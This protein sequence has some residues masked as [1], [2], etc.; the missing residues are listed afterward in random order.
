P[1]AH[2]LTRTRSLHGA[3]PI[4]LSRDGVAGEYMDNSTWAFTAI[5]CLDS[6]PGEPTTIEEVQ[7]FA[8]QMKEASPTFGWWFSSGAG[9]EGWPDRK[10]TRLNS[11]HVSISC[12]V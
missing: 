2:T 4:Y 6:E 10:S 11:S 12:A 5:R 1:A 7:E 9:C 8:A 3:L